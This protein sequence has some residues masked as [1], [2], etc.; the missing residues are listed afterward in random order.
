[1][2]LENF[3][4]VYDYL[5]LEERK[6]TIAIID[7]EPINWKRANEEI[8]KKTKLGGRIQKLMEKRGLL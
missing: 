5:P 2:S 1:M 6:M 7:G 3:V 8:I 4:K